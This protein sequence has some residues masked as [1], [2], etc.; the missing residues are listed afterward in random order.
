MIYVAY[1][2]LPLQYSAVVSLVYVVRNSTL[3]YRF[4][5]SQWV[6]N[7]EIHRDTSRSW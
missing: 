3:L 7:S 2:V 1:F 6:L 4:L 5:K